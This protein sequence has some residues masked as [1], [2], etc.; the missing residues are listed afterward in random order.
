MSTNPRLGVVNE[1]CQ[2]H[3]INNLYIAGSSV[4]PTGGISNPTLTIVALATRLADH[5][6]IQMDRSTE[7]IKGFESTPTQLDEIKI[8]LTNASA[9]LNEPNLV[10]GVD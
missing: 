10:P 8:P 1:H 4:F 7:V 6:K 3:G 9:V 2:V 5:I